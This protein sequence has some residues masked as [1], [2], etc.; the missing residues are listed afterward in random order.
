MTGDHR[1]LADGVVDLGRGPDAFQPRA[2]QV[3]PP[4]GADRE[5]RP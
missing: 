3:A 2:L 1:L 4:P 5:D